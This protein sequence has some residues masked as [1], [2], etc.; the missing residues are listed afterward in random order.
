[1]LELSYQLDVAV[2][3]VQHKSMWIECS[4]RERATSR[5][6]IARLQRCDGKGQS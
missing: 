3:S 6:T 4:G 2:N 5:E 1:M